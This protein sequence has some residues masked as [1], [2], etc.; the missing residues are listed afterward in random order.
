MKVVNET[1]VDF[2]FAFFSATLY[3]VVNYWNAPRLYRI[4]FI[5]LIRLWI[6]YADSCCINLGNWN[7]FQQDNW[8]NYAWYFVFTMI[9]KTRPWRHIYHDIGIPI[10]KNHNIE[11]PRPKNHDIEIGGLKHHDIIKWRQISDEIV[12]PKRF[13]RGQKAMTSRFQD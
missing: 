1:S 2:V 11:I 3:V 8:H 9:T 7:I 12:I 10:P 6:H 5:I 13:F 4:L